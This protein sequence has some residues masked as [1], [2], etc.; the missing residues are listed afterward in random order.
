MSK[1]QEL[2]PIVALADQLQSEEGPIVLV[3]VFTVDA[4]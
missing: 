4:A 3:N 2:D 1:L